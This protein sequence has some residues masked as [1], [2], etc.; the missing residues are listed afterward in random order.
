MTPV[1]PIATKCV[2][3]DIIP[4]R[5]ELECLLLKFEQNEGIHTK[6]C[7][8]YSDFF[9]NKSIEIKIDAF[10]CLATL[11]LP[12]EQHCFNIN[13]K[14]PDISFLISNLGTENL[15]HQ[16]IKY[17][18]CD[19]E[20]ILKIFSDKNSYVH[21]FIIFDKDSVILK[22]LYKINFKECG[23][24]LFNLMAEM[25]YKIY[26]KGMCYGFTFMAIQAFLRKD[27]NSYINRI[28]NINKIID[29][30]ETSITYEQK[31]KM[32]ANY[33]NADNLS[34]ITE[35]STNVDILLKNILKTI[36]HFFD[37]VVM[38]QGLSLRKMIDEDVKN[39]FPYC[40]QSYRPVLELFADKSPE[41][42]VSDGIIPFG[43]FCVNNRILKLFTAKDLETLIEKVFLS[44]EQIG[45]R[46]SSSGH[47]I[48]VCGSAADGCFLVNN[49]SCSRLYSSK[50]GYLILAL[51]Y[52]SCPLTFPL[53]IEEFG[54][55]KYIPLI[56]N[57]E[58]QLIN[59]TTLSVLDDDGYGIFKYSITFDFCEVAK[60]VFNFIDVNGLGA[61]FKRSV[62]FFRL[63]NGLKDL[64]DDNHIE[65]VA[66]CF[67]WLLNTATLTIKEKFTLI[68]S[69]ANNQGKLFH[70]ACY[71]F[72]DIVKIMTDKVCQFKEFTIEQKLLF[73]SAKNKYGVSALF[74]AAQGGHKGVVTILLDAVCSSAIFT[75]NQ[76]FNFIR[77]ARSD[78]I[79]ALFMPAQNGHKEVVKILLEA[80]CHSDIFTIN[81]KVNFLLSA[82]RDGV[83]ALF[84]A[85]NQGH[86][87]VVK[88][89]TQCISNLYGL[90]NQERI[91]LWGAN[92]P[93]GVSALQMAS[94]L[95]YS[96]TVEVLV[97]GILKS[98]TF[99]KDEKFKLISNP[100]K[101][102]YSCLYYSNDYEKKEVTDVIIKTVCLS[103]VFPN[104]QKKTFLLSGANTLDGVKIM[105]KDTTL[106]EEDKSELLILVE[107][108]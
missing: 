46:I 28:E 5:S 84:I 53:M 105:I 93:D 33:L 6:I 8:C 19:L 72:S 91:K 86:Y 94:M 104:T 2:S 17:E 100:Y 67:D 75:I 65:L 16:T 50:Q 48:A 42:S 74:I 58:F 106:S 98:K 77:S 82:R 66:M 25:K 27:F 26:D 101:G 47:A 13:I 23:S 51:F 85:A 9:A 54:V 15:L 70:S 68:N 1:N 3:T 32:L 79:S 87:E 61:G 57:T 108:K 41:F 22:E 62:M 103:N 49:D 83:S 10:M 34:P 43:G 55:Q 102:R 71:N 36:K 35:K 40:N 63:E 80:V 37:G 73:L 99:L 56:S 38:Y 18:Q 89:F 52:K 69:A 39:L 64:G 78:G 14:D 29:T 7:K 90:T 81:Q 30:Y 92:R 45:L 60:A 97:K 76:K 107:N 44:T 96:K 20:N 12:S 95:G 24:L 4:P 88:I 31:V 11:A 59:E 21:K